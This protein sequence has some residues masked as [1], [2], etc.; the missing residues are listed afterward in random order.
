MNRTNLLTRR[1]S[2]VFIFILLWTIASA[3]GIYLRLYPLRHASHGAIEKATV[4]VITNVRNAVARTIEKDHPDLSDIEKKQRAKKQFDAVLHEDGEKI[5]MTIST[6]ARRI[7][8]T[9]PDDDD[10]LYLL[11]SDSYYYYGLTQNIL[12]TGTI[13][14]KIKGSKFFHP[15]MLAP[16][17]YWEPLNLHP[18]VGAFVYKIISLFNPRM[19]LMEA[20][21]YTPLILTAMV[22]VPFFLLCRFLGC[23]PGVT[24][25]GAVYLLCAPIFL[26]RSMFGWYDDDPYNLFFSFLILGSVLYAV[27]HRADRR[28]L[29]RWA[30]VYAFLISC[31]ALFW[32]G[33]VLL[34]SL[35]TM[36]LVFMAFDNY[37]IVREKETT[38]HLLFY[39]G[40]ITAGTFLGISAVFGP[41]EFFV[42]FREGW[43][44]LQDFLHPKLALWPDLY[45]AVGELTSASPDYLMDLVGGVFFFSTA[46]L[47]FLIQFF[48]GLRH[49]RPNMN[50]YAAFLLGIFLVVTIKLT[51]GAQRFA[52][53]CLIPV[54]LLFP[55]ALQNIADILD[56]IFLKRLFPKIRES[57][58]AVSL[59][60][61]I[62]MAVLAITPFKKAQAKTPELLNQIFNQV[63]DRA[64]TTIKME[65]PEDS[66]VNTWWPPGHFIKAIAERR[67]TFDGATINKPQ[68]YWMANVFL[69]DDEK[70]SAGLLRMLNGSGNRAVEYL[71]QQGIPLSRAVDI[72]KKIASLDSA[73]A[74]TELQSVLQNDQIKN[75]L[76]LTHLPPPPSYLLIYNEIVEKNIQFSFVGKWNFKKIEEINENPREHSSV[77][78]SR[79]PGYIK[80]LWDLAGGPPRYSEPLMTFAR[81]GNTVLF[82]QN[83]RVDLATMDCSINSSKFGKGTPRSI[84]YEKDGE[85][86]EKKFSHAN[87]PYSVMLIREPKGYTC[88]LADTGLAKSLLMRL[89]F[90]GGKG[91]NY[92]E[93]F[94]EEKDPTGR[95][96]ILVYKVNWEKFIR[97]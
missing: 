11:A 65:T 93:P 58:P 51:L 72:L 18:F 61:I 39:L 37:I 3:L 16:D 67:V 92:F 5:R 25:I 43:T 35:V 8:E 22:L 60:I 19:P 47:G 70:M 41:L 42:L 26:R 84:V 29:F 95:T 91:L 45:M 53:L 90:Y 40:M 32:H 12:R 36:A 21:S 78:E 73:H 4:I 97:D 80:F 44:A 81:R 83:V 33:W 30:I 7:D 34:A 55:I 27:K 10:K 50:R 23:S 14:P 69:S 6:V 17:G 49:P 56:K 88:I 63:W 52:T 79:S 24:F 31:Y 2:R 75:L 94:L 74:R 57:A 1:P 15:L 96:H 68:A 13:G 66:I 89:Y 20:V 62:S 85:F 77:P 82:E 9:S 71:T 48:K 38:R 28:I 87:L 64:L 86:F 46:L 54:S 76:D 59:I